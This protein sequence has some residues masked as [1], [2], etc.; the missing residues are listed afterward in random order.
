MVQ[1]KVFLRL[2]LSRLEFRFCLETLVCSLSE[3]QMSL[4]SVKMICC[5]ALYIA[6]VIH[7]VGPIGE[8]PK[9]L[10]SCYD[11]CLETMLELQQ[12]T[13]VSRS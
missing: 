7:T 10:R 11:N 1:G 4:Q 9:L 8:K 5:S 13:I 2:R 12:K 6:D 3:R